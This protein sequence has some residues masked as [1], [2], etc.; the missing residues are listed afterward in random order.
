MSGIFVPEHLK[1]AQVNHSKVKTFFTLKGFEPTHDF[2]LLETLMDYQPPDDVKLEIPQSI[3]DKQQTCRV[4]AVGPGG[5]MPNGEINM[6]C[7]RPGDLVFV[8]PGNYNI[9]TTKDAPG[10][11]FQLVHDSSILGIFRN[12][13]ENPPQA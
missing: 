7:C 13:S 11:Q 9:L 1:Q 4:I 6:P 3:V 8:A 2:I 12:Q 5:R 10:R